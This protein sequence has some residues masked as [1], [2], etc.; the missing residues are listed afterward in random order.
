MIALVSI[1]LPIRL[2]QFLVSSDDRIE[3]YSFVNFE[4]IQKEVGSD[5]RPTSGRALPDWKEGSFQLPFFI[6]VG[7][8]LFPSEDLAGGH[9]PHGPLSMLFAYPHQT[10]LEAYPFSTNRVRKLFQA[11]T[12]R[13][14]QQADSLASLLH[15]VCGSQR[16][17]GPGQRAAH[18]RASLQARPWLIG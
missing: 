9:R 4:P 14:D 6:D 8:R 7:L 16:A 15:T 3:D 11:R 17:G 10:E 13:S 5:C 12:T 18:K 2:P 1:G